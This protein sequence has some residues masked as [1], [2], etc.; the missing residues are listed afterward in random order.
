LHCRKVVHRDIKL[1]NILINKIDDGDLKVIIA[2]FGLAC[3]AP[4]E[5][6]TDKCGTPCYLA[7]EMLR[8]QGYGLKCDIFSLGSVF[9]N[10]VTGFYLFNGSNAEEVV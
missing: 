6:L 5:P 9:F 1:D 10:L 3:L 8:G 4:D 7:P 2:D